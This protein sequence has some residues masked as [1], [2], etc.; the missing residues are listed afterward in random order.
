MLFAVMVGSNML[1]R[2]GFGGD[3]S[4]GLEQSVMAVALRGDESSV[5]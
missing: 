3:S 1:A 2:S 4:N 5:H